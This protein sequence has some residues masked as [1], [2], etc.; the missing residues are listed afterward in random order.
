MTSN[1]NIKKKR[2]HF[3]LPGGGVN[4]AFQA[5]FLYRLMSDYSQ[6]I[7]IERIDGI[8]V[9][10]LNGIC[11]LLEHP[12]LIKNIWYSIE[13]RNN[14]FDSHPTNRD[15]WEKGSLYNSNGLREIVMTYKNF[16]NQNHLIKFNCV[17]HNS[18]KQCYEYI[19]GLDD[20]IWDFIIASASPPMLSPYS[21]IGEEF[22]TDGGLDLV[23]PIDYIENDNSIMNVVVGY[24]NDTDYYLFNLYKYMK[25]SIHDNIIKICELLKDSKVISVN[26]PCRN[27]IIDFRRE[28]IEVAFQSGENSAIKFISEYIVI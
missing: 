15:V 17:V 1:E 12:E 13:E 8:S 2:I 26:N 10:A 28:I 6:Y 11:I 9:G 24:Y 4:G 14:I 27:N 5:G 16:I 23:Y 20:N 22:Y 19:N 3:I 25:K 18:N 7:E 21:K